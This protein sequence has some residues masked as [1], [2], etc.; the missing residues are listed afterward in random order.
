MATALVGMG[1]NLGDRQAALEAA[2]ASLAGRA[3]LR[4]AAVSGFRETAPIG[5]PQDQPDYLNAALR[6]E[7]ELDPRSLLHV[8]QGLE[9]ELGRV[10]SERWGPRTVDLDLLL[11]DDL[12]LDTPE[13]TLPHP[14]MSFRRF[15]LEPAAEVGGKMVHPTTGWTVNRLLEHLKTA[16]PYVAVLTASPELVQRLAAALDAKLVRMDWRGYV[17]G[18]WEQQGRIVRA[19]A[20]SLEDAQLTLNGEFVVSDCRVDHFF[21][22]RFMRRE[23]TGVAAAIDSAATPRLS[24]TWDASPETVQDLDEEPVTALEPT[25]PSELKNFARFPGRGPICHLE[26]KNLDTALAE[27]VASV[28]AMD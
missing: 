27:A 3:D 24:I 16:K 10:R 6:L 1:S 9:N 11:Y 2:V 22:R 15:V 26:A 23:D 8:L 21:W 7:T 20:E 19:F 5:G 18:S 13:L 14:R 25:Q 28:R 4:V 12:T 17:R